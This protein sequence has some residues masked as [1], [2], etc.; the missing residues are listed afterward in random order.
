MTATVVTP[1]IKKISLSGYRAFPPY[2]PKSLDIDLG[3][4]G[5]N[6][7]LYGENGS[8]KTSLFR[9]LRD[10]FDTSSD[11]RDFASVRNIFQQDEDDSVVISLTSG[12]PD[13]YRWED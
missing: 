11:S 5:K 2:K 12:T 10:I 3:D 7:L 6:L 8:G 1:K 4:T 13:E 9:A